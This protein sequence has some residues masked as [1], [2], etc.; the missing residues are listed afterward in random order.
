MF[1]SKR[2]RGVWW[3]CAA[4]VAV[5]AAGC[6]SAASEELGGG[7]PASAAE[8]RA[9]PV[10]PSLVDGESGGVESGGSIA[11]GVSAGGGDAPSVSSTSSSLVDGTSVFGVEGEDEISEEELEYLAEIRDALVYDRPDFSDYSDEEIVALAFHHR[12]LLVDDPWSVDLN[13]L[14][15]S[16]GALCWVILNAFMWVLLSAF[17]IVQIV[18]FEQFALHPFYGAGGNLR[19]WHLER[20]IEDRGLELFW[21]GGP[22]DDML[23]LR[24]VLLTAREVRG[25]VFGSD[26]LP[27]LRPLAEELYVWIDDLW[28]LPVVRARP[29][30]EELA[31]GYGRGSP[32]RGLEGITEEEIARIW[33]EEFGVEL[34]GE[35]SKD[36]EELLFW[37]R[38]DEEARDLLNAG[39]EVRRNDWYAR[40][41]PAWVADVLRAGSEC[42]REP[43]FECPF[44]SAS[45][46]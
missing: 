40:A 30:L 24:R 20:E 27:V 3:A 22:V 45:E 25:V 5:L 42:R 14:S 2:V 38:D 4:A 19:V 8:E 6:V 7:A 13:D 11:G 39:C 41:C 26:L 46:C 16:L 28:E 44:G 37:L 17:M 10:L 32:Y 29:T 31:S 18:S 23:T 36:F 9:A 15:T 33:P 35:G 1:N 12:A 21:E 43:E 34:T